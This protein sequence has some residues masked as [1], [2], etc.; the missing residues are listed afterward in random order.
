MGDYFLEAETERITFDDGQWCDIKQELTQAD[1]D[2]IMAQMVRNGST[3]LSLGRL[4]LLERAV[5]AW[6]FQDKDGKSV[7][8]NSDTISNL[9]R[10]Y[11][12]IILQ[13]VDRLNLESLEFSKKS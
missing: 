7:S 13:K 12:T 3:Q 4:P 8:V 10:K 9:R 11:R 2:Y 1:S 5:V 6:S